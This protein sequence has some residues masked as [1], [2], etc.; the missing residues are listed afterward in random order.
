VQPGQ[1]RDQITVAFG[2][3]EVSVVALLRANGER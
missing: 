1:M 2:T 3:G